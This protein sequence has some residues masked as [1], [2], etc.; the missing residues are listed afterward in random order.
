MNF[1][2][3]LCTSRGKLVV[4]MVVDRLSKYFAL[5]GPVSSLHSQDSGKGVSRLG[6]TVTQGAKFHRE[7]S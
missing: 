3:G 2:E 6:G 7:S 1:V 5:C 4:L